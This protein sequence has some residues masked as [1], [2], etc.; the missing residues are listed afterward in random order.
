MIRGQRVFM[1]CDWEPSN[2]P[3][4]TISWW[5]RR[6]RTVPQSAT[7]AEPCTMCFVF[8]TS[9]SLHNKPMR[10]CQRNHSSESCDP[11]MLL[12][13]NK[14][15]AIHQTKPPCLEGAAFPFPPPS[16]T[17][18]LQS[19]GSL[20]CL[21][22]NSC[23]CTCGHTPVG[24]ASSSIEHWLGLYMW[25]WY[26]EGRRVLSFAVKTG[27]DVA[28]F[29]SYRVWSRPTRL[30]DCNELDFHPLPSFRFHSYFLLDTVDQG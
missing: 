25:L 22:A 16:P 20:V 26:P 21:F 13:A 30:S 15:L 8:I 18:S 10:S 1:A 5:W 14:F 12:G 9:S 24:F 19:L 27:Q 4:N 11:R 7:W 23:S 6:Q 2:S 29:C 17:H 3:H 28:R